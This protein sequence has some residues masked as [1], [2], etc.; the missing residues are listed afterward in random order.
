MTT[1]RAGPVRMRTTRQY[2]PGSSHIGELAAQSRNV[3]LTSITMLF[4]FRGKPFQI[5]L[6]NFGICILKIGT[7]TAKLQLS[8]SKSFMWEQFKFIDLEI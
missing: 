4:M 6:W 2:K 8:S 3:R 7:E 5:G 1:P